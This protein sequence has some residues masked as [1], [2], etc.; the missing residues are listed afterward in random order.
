ME[1]LENEI[2]KDVV[3]WESCYQ[4]SN[5]GRLKGKEKSYYI[6]T[7][8][9]RR[10]ATRKE[11]ILNPK[12]NQN[13][14]RSATLQ[15]NNIRKDVLIHRLVA[16]AFIP[17]PN[18]KKIINHKNSIRHDNRVENLEWCNQQEN[19][20]HAWLNG[21]HENA[22]VA[23]NAANRLR[24]GDLCPISKP[25]INIENGVFYSSIREAHEA[26]GHYSISYFEMMLSGKNKNKTPYILIEK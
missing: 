25:T 4:I 26:Y 2:W 8:E 23:R 5:M 24:T 7:Q 14:Y 6:G 21:R 12:F 13:R 16:E 11:V 19:V 3:G 22:R 9:T 18:K 15:L 1:N 17:N 10:L 20:I